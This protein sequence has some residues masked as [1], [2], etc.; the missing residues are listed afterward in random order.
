MW[1]Q[2]ENLGERYLLKGTDGSSHSGKG[3]GGNIFRCRPDGSRLQLF[4]TGF[5]NPFGLAFYGREFLL[6]VDNDPDSRPPNRLLDVVRHGDYGYKFRFGRSGL[7]PFQAWN[8]EL[9]GTLPMANGTGE[10]ASAVLPC[11]PTQ[12]PASYRGAALVTAAWDHQVEVQRLKPFGATLRSDREVLVQGDDNF[13]PVGLTSTPDGAVFIT[14]WVDA[15]YNV[16]RKGRI[17]RLAAKSE[18][19][20]KPLSSFSMTP[21]AQRKRMHRLLEVDSVGEAGDLLSA[22]SNSD[23]FVRSAAVSTLAQPKFHAVVERATADKSSAIRLGALL[24]LRRASV[25]D[26]ARFVQGF[27]RDID[28]QVRLMSVVWAG[29]ERM[30]SVTNDLAFALSA[31][32]VTP[33]LLRAH[34]AAV[35]IF[36]RESK[37]PGGAASGPAKVA[38]FELQ[39]RVEERPF[40]EVLGSK[41]SQTPR[42]VRLDAVRRLAQTTNLAGQSLL[43]RLAL[44]KKETAELR[45]EAIVSL[46]GAT[47]EPGLFL[48]LLKDP[49]PAVRAEAAR[50]L[51]GW[52]N[53]GQVQAEVTRRLAETGGHDLALEEQLRLV[54]SI[55]GR[56]PREARPGTDAEWRVA[57]AGAGD[58]ASGRRVFFQPAVGCAR[59]HRIE[60]H[61]GRIGPDLSAIARGADR[62]KLIQSILHPSRDIAP[63]FVGHTVETRDGDVFTGLLIGQSTE[64]G[65]TLFTADGKAVVIPGALIASQAQSKVSLM[66]EGLADLLTLRDFRDLLAFLLDRR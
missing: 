25:E 66:P 48:W 35:Q 11:E 1:G 26:A 62:E 14:D 29:E 54:A 37:Q 44:D 9:P 13:R 43:R 21:N 28:P 8:G 2:G 64:V 23:P 49:A 55:G 15:S 5:W 65:L 32:P 22:L 38:F 41:A 3:E 20:A 4:A 51:R 56:R 10:G 19:R 59:C 45:A 61:G 63:Q 18:H 12:L 16:H 24:A 27:L 7:H 47:A 46:A 58:A 57:L 33:A 36:S 39:E 6:A 60:D 30:V 31:G 17:W 42:Q 34:A 52:A 53:E 50:A 40:V